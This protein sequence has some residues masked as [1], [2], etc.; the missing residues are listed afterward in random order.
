MWSIGQAR[1]HICPAAAR[2]QAETSR[3]ALAGGRAAIERKRHD[4]LL[5]LMAAGG[6]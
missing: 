6:D 4:Q 3:I 2:E 5:N 1:P